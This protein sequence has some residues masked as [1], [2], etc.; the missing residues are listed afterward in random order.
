MKRILLTL[1]LIAT[2]F[3]LTGCGENKVELEREIS[4]LK[5]DMQQATKVYCIA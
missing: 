5:I 3:S 4:N 1:I 2:C